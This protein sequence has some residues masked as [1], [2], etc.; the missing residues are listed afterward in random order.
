MLIPHIQIFLMVQTSTIT[1]TRN[2]GD[3]IWNKCK[4]VYSQF[5]FE[6]NISFCRAGHVSCWVILH[7]NLNRSNK[8]HPE[9]CLKSN[10]KTISALTVFAFHLVGNNTWIIF[11]VEGANGEN[12]WEFHKNHFC[13]FGFSAFDPICFS[14]HL[15]YLSYNQ[16]VCT[17]TVVNYDRKT[18]GT[19]V[20]KTLV[21]MMLYILTLTLI[22][23]IMDG[24]ILNHIRL[25]QSPEC[26]GKVVWKLVW[27]TWSGLVWLNWLN[28]YGYEVNVL[29][30][31]WRGR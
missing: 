19:L 9:F 17:C 22:C 1:V 16:T 31:V 28:W 29:W 30:M 20:W 14:Y 2:D 27:S 7:L 25:S 13:S 15:D 24:Y 18:V 26:N 10:L 23:H 21:D 5:M 11:L 3:R 8:V 4:T 6:M 12:I